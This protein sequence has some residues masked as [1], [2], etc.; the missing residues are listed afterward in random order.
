[1]TYIPFRL[2]D[3]TPEDCEID[4]WT[5]TFSDRMVIDVED[6]YYGYEVTMVRDLQLVMFTMD[7][8]EAES[9][10]LRTETLKVMMKG[11]S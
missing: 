11:Y 7:A 9:E 3:S 10:Y 5:I 8:F 4:G 2:S 1:M 6:S